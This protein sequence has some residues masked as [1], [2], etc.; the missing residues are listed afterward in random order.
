M[1]RTTPLTEMI[2]VLEPRLYLCNGRS[3]LTFQIWLMYDICVYSNQKAFVAF[4]ADC[5]LKLKGFLR[6]Q[7]DTYTVKVVISQKWCKI[8]TL[9]LQT[10]N[11]KCHMAY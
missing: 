6:L 4:N 3:C 10:T 8:D 11:R 7:A 5:L 9:L 2:Y 1:T